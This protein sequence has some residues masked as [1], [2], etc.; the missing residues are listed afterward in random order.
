MDLFVLELP[1]V[2]VVD[3][4]DVAGA[5]FDAEW[6]QTPLTAAVRVVHVV[7]EAGERLGSPRRAHDHVRFVYVPVAGVTQVP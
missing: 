4:G 5:E 6:R 7:S 3:L 1:E 2:L